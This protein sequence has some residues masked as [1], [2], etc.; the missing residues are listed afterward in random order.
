MCNARLAEPEG[1][2]WLALAGDPEQDLVRGVGMTS[3]PTRLT[4]AGLAPCS[5]WGSG[6]TCMPRSLGQPSPRTAPALPAAAGCIQKRFAAVTYGAMFHSHKSGCSAHTVTHP[7][8]LNTVQS[9][10][11]DSGLLL[12]NKQTN[13]HFTFCLQSKMVSVKS[14]HQVYLCWKY[15]VT[16]WVL[17]DACLKY[18]LQEVLFTTKTKE[19]TKQDKTD[20]RYSYLHK[21]KFVKERRKVC[22]LTLLMQEENGWKIFTTHLWLRWPLDTNVCGPAYVLYCWGIR[23]SHLRHQ[24]EGKV[25]QEKQPGL[26]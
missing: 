20:R 1:L 22:V 5:L 18:K 12:K 16:L 26:K 19:I 6:H 3:A 24:F 9:R 7:L 4:P 17:V 2:G 23:P 13:K 15:Q 10:G 14:R 21:S 11:E 8:L 25:P